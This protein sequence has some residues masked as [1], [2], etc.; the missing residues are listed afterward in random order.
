T[1]LPV[2]EIKQY[3]YISYCVGAQVCKCIVYAPASQSFDVH[4]MK[5]EKVFSYTSSVSNKTFV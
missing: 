4:D 3:E 2:V 5:T 1:V